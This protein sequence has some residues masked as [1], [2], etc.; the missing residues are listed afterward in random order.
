[1]ET[2]LKLQVPPTDIERMRQHPV[3]AE[4]AVGAPT[5][6]RRTDTYY[7]TPEHALWKHGLTLRVREQDGTFIQ[8]VK[9]AD[10]PSPGLHR[11]GEWE[12]ELPDATPQP[13]LLARQIKPARVAAPLTSDD[14]AT[15]LQPVFRNTTQR[16]TWDI[17]LPDGEQVEC[18]L[19]AGDI[20]SG[21]RHTPIAEL[22]LEL[23]SG[24]PA[25]LF[26]LALA[27][28]HDVPLRMANDS[29]AARGYAL[30]EP[31]TPQAI[32]AARVRLKKSMSLE[33]AFQCIG[34]NCLRQM[35][36]NVTGVLARDV[37]SLHQMRVGLRRLRALLDMFEELTVP[38]ADIADGLEWLAG[39]LGATRD[40][41]VLA[42]STLDRI[43]GND[44][45]ALRDAARAKAARLHKHMLD[46]LH[47]P[48]F[49]ELM[50]RLN[51]WLQGRQWRADGIPQRAL[52]ASA[53][54][55][56]QP[57]LRKAEKRL[58][59]RIGKLDPDDAPA[60][61]RVRIAAKKARYAAE[62]FRDLLPKQSVKRYVANL[63]A[64]QDQ[65]GLMNDVAVAER[66]LPELQHGNGELARQAAYA[67]GY[68]RAGTGADVRALKKPLAAIARL[69]MRR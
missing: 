42:A 31:A 7:D 49:T 37:E 6:H 19:D 2:E 30:S 15:R 38:P 58:A 55:G 14:I 66:L 27:L 35:E 63:S 48:R 36:A 54:D 29:K 12:C 47:V 44:T 65:L 25:Q 69:R 59:Q 51:A 17:R 22:E 40:W 33:D 4:H 45:A 67:R 56:A 16:T 68:L 28:H 34:L 1:M 52:T 53:A 32:K 18:A 21:E 11:R 8:T 20:A 26:D 61:H 23:K 10:G 9:T 50:L 24:S 43:D 39:E 46:T 60:R 5:E 57:L 41:D 62:F 64:L 3:L 13:A